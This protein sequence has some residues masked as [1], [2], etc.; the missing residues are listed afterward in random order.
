M[1]G[2]PWLAAD[3]PGGCGVAI[4][5]SRIGPLDMGIVLAPLVTLALDNRHWLVDGPCNVPPTSINLIAC[6]KVKIAGG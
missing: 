4:S 5:A 2:I 3:N 1:A 6:Y